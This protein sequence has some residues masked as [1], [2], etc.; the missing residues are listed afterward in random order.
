[1]ECGEVVVVSGRQLRR[2][3]FELSRDASPRRALPS[4]K[5]TTNTRQCHTTQLG[6]RERC[7][8]PMASIRSLG[9][10]TPAALPYLI[11]EGILPDD[12]PPDAYS[13]STYSDDDGEEEITATEHCVV[14]SRGGIIRKVYNFEVEGE[15]VLQ[16]VLTWFPSDEATALRNTTQDLR[17]DHGPGT[18]FAKDRVREPGYVGHDEKGSGKQSPSDGQLEKLSR[19]LVVFLKTQ[20][21]VFFLAGSSHVVNLPFEVE[22]VFPAPRGLLI[23][24]KMSIPDFTPISPAV[25]KAPP[26]S[27]FSQ[28]PTQ[29]FSQNSSLFTPMV[30]PSF[31]TPRRSKSSSGIAY[32][33]SLADLLKIG[34]SPSAD[35]LPRLFSFTDPFS[36]MG[37]VVASQS[38]STRTSFS[39]R[40]SASKTLEPVDKAEEVLYVTQQ[41]EM[42]GSDNP[43]DKPLILVITVNY[44]RRIYSVWYAS[45]IDPKPASAK[46]APRSSTLS[47]GR[48]RRRSSIHPGTGATTPA[49]RTREGT[50]D[51]VGG[52]GYANTSFTASQTRET[53][54]EQQTEEEAFASQLD[55]ETDLARQP[56][57]ESRRVSSLL[58]R[59]DLSRSFDKSAFEQATHRSSLGSNFSHS[60]RGQS[61]GG[62]GLR[63][64][65]G[66]SSRPVSRKTRAS[67]P[68]DVSQIS[69]SAVSLEDTVDDDL[70]LDDT[71][72]DSEIPDELL[73]GDGDDASGLQE[74]IEGLRRELLLVKFSEIPFGTSESIFR[75]SVHGNPTVRVLHSR[76]ENGIC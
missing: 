17:Q 25:P 8:L 59:A 45:Y 28:L 13:W 71:I 27:F 53:S 69:L 14:W 30:N 57:R 38:Q 61:L 60:R 56:T 6:P 54:G 2:R 4:A 42:T 20:A 46:K 63:A 18:L 9:V 50:R 3:S 64:S 51:S 49:L 19:A 73:G 43:A 5:S 23:Q 39:V 21:H 37:L 32:P 40:P 67:T 48:S 11:Q 12:A 55:P 70:E 76:E 58:S 75:S 10:R 35:G 24:R 16:A 29:S 15:K 34:T 74:P 68:G 7:S 22:R 1:M 72:D 62:H 41:N 26:N 47:V 52:R 65:L 66:P 44:E 33:S 31:A 36:E